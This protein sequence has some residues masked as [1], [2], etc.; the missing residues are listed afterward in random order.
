MLQKIQIEISPDELKEI[1]KE[2][3]IEVQSNQSNQ[4]PTNSNELLTTKELAKLLRKTPKTIYEWKMNNKIPYIQT[5]K[6][7][8]YDKDEVLNSLKNWKLI[9][10]RGTK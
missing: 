3:L 1:I 6:A 4:T 2:T 10:H 9:N 8:L 5:D 7:I